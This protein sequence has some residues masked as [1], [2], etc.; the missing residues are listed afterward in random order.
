MDLP[1]TQFRTK[2]EQ[3]FLD[4]FVAADHGVIQN[5]FGITGYLCD[6]HVAK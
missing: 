6:H 2:A 5:T 4:Q 1:V 3:A